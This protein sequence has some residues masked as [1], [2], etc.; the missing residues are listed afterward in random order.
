MSANIETLTQET[1]LTDQQ[2]WGTFLACT[3]AT[4]YPPLVNA[5]EAEVASRISNQ[6]ADAARGAAAVMAMN[7]VY[8]RFT[9]IAKNGNAYAK[10]PAKLKM[11]VISE[12]GI[13]K[14]DFELFSLA[15]SAI[16]GCG[17]CV[18][19]H[20]RVLLQHGVTTE[21]IQTTVRIGS[22]IDALAK[23]HSATH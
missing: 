1:L 5:V 7:N 15:V 17:L 13:E 16:N 21:T 8:Y 19:A 6:A 9:H 2:K 22:V 18:D 3:H 20:E 12:H 4:G 11:K 14:V 10:L 23:V